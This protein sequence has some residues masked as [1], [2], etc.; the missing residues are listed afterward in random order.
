VEWAIPQRPFRAQKRH[1]SGLPMGYCRRS[2]RDYGH[3]LEDLPHGSPVLRTGC[4][5]G[6]VRN[7]CIH[8]RSIV[9]PQYGSPWAH[10]AVS[11]R[12]GEQCWQ[13]I[14]LPTTSEV[15]EVGCI[16]EHSPRSAL[17][18][19]AAV[20]LQVVSTLQPGQFRNAF[21]S[22]FV[23]LGLFLPLIPFIPESPCEYPLSDGEFCVVTEL[24]GTM[25]GATNTTRR[26]KP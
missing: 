13:C 16:V 18:E 7:H 5:V 20:A 3:E 10:F 23:F 6:P 25:L 17:T 2:T 19:T 26:R 22:Q 11:L 1:V 8:K 4:W 9:S 15:S 21:Y 12:S 14:R 24:Q